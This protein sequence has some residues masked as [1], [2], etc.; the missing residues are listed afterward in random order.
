M[1]TASPTPEPTARPG[2]VGWRGFGLVALGV[3]NALLLVWGSAPHSALHNDVARQLVAV[4]A[5]ASVGGAAL[6]WIA[7]ERRFEGMPVACVL[8]LALV[9]RLIATQA[10][11]LLEDDHFR[12][13]WDGLRTATHFDPY[14]FAPSAFFGQQ[15][16]SAPW[17][18]ILSG[19]N[20]PDIATIYGPVLQLF[21]A[22]A[23]W[24]APGRLGAIQGLLLVAD[25]A[26]L[27]LLLR[28]RV[29]TRCLL[30]YALHPLI[31][32]EAMASAHPDGLVALF[33]LLALVA[34]QRRRAAWV[35]V[36]L[37]LAVGTKVSAVVAVPFLLMWPWPPTP[38]DAAV[39]RTAWTLSC[40]AGCAATLALLYL[41]FILAGGS[42]AAALST[43]AG[44]W[45]FNP[46]LYRLV[47]AAVP[48][49]ASATLARPLAA[50]LAA[51]G[52]MALVWHWRGGM[53]RAAS[54]ALPPLDA[55]LV[56]LLLLSPV[57]N[58]WYWLWALALSARLGR[59]WMAAGGVL[60]VLSCVNSTVWTEAA[61]WSGPE[62]AGPYWVPWPLALVQVMGLLAA[63]MLSRCR[64]RDKDKD[65]NAASAEGPRIRC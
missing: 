10:S 44:Q 64:C 19:I 13:L 18:D 45:R 61:L 33:L 65:R 16:L 50:A 41:P 31:L 46:L 40:G 14:R 21:F 6:L 17:Q 58:A 32:K 29:G 7:L 43:F 8:G 55:A 57:V 4:L 54:P 22:L 35:G 5:G 63:F 47:E 24:V 39:N 12:Y 53:R 2:S 38:K 52:V 23:Y 3:T 9:L 28:Q 62:A 42:D 49:A 20:N 11:P 27:W 25:M 36:L 60:G 34:W 15:D 37:A 26:V 1:P 30:I 56:L 48:A 59:T 51:A